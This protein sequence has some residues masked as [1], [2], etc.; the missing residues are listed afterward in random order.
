MKTSKK[1]KA[2]CIVGIV[3]IIFL[4]AIVIFRPKNNSNNNDNSESTSLYQTNSNGQSYGY[5]E[6]TSVEQ[7][8]DLIPAKGK[9]GTDGYMRKEDYLGENT[10]KY[11]VYTIDLSGDELETARKQYMNQ[12]EDVS[13]VKFVKRCFDIPLFDVSGEIEVDQFRVNMGYYPYPETE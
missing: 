6:T 1:L 3:L 8:P 13:T 9:N 11:E 2:C 4:G 5:A 7:L 10:E 12:Y